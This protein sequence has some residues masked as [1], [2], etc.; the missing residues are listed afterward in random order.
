M[1]ARIYWK[2]TLYSRMMLVLL[3]SRLCNRISSL[4]PIIHETCQGRAFNGGRELFMNYNDLCMSC[5][6]ASVSGW[7]GFRWFSPS[8]WYINT[9]RLRW[10]IKYLSKLTFIRQNDLPYVILTWLAVTFDLAT[11]Q[12]VRVWFIPGPD[13]SLKGFSFM[14][15]TSEE[16]HIKRRIYGKS[17]PPIPSRSRDGEGGP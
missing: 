7:T 9:W 15:S 4:S 12:W 1:R 17:H 11:S 13:L 3:I 10:I 16:F 8:L 6:S 2:I 5:P 14:I